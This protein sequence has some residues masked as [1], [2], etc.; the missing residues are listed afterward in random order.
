MMLEKLR[1]EVL[2]AALNL[3]R[4]NL[5]TLT[6]GNVSG[7]DPETGYIAVTPSGLE[8]EKLSPKD[9]VIV[10]IDNNKIDG[11]Y[12]QSV[13]TEDLLYIY[14]HM[15]E[16]NGII[17]THSIFAQSFAILNEEIPCC[18]TTLANEV[19]GSVPVAEYAPVA[20]DG[21]GP[22]VVKAIGDKRACLLANHGVITVGPDVRH[23][24]VAAVMLEDSA[25]AYL[26]AKAIGNPVILP[27]SEVQKAREVFFNIYGQGK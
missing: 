26:F 5:I 23:A 2:D 9:I 18:C 14:K 11:E 24:I 21:I 12:K 16:V 7:R 3:E 6:G 27:D 1:E 20:S 25:K 17:H 19:G 13:D 10:D 8:Y 15:P 4:Y 22:S